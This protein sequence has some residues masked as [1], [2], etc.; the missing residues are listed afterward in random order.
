M[1]ARRTITGMFTRIIFSTGQMF[2]T[3]QFRV[4]KVIEN[5]P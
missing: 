3:K 2:I 1:Q 5:I 4:S